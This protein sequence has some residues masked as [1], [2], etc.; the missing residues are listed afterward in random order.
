MTEAQLALVRAIVGDELLR[1]DLAALTEAYAN[2]K[3]G[4]ETLRAADL[5]IPTAAEFEARWTP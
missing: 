5:E 4:L 2:Y 3:R 1:T